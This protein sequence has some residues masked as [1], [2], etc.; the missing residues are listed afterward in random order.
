MSVHSL[1]RSTRS[2]PALA[3]VA[4]LLAGALFLATA[5][6][7]AA[8]DRSAPLRSVQTAD[9]ELAAINDMMPGFGGMFLDEAGT[10]T[11]YVTADRAG[12]YRKAFGGTVR[13]I[14][15]QWEF[16]Q[17]LR[18]RSDLRALLHAPGVVLLDADE[19]KNRVRVGVAP[20][21]SH[22]ARRMIEARLRGLGVPDGAVVFDETEPIHPL[23]TL[24]DAFSP[25]PGGVE[26]HWSNFLCT[27]GFNIRRGDATDACYF[28]TND[29]CTD[30]QGTVTGTIYRQ[31]VFGVQ[32][33]EEV[34][35]PPFFTGAPCPAGRICRYSDAA[36]ARYFDPNNCEF[37][38]IA[39]TTGIGSVT[40]DPVNPRWMIVAKILSPPVGRIVA[41]TGRT[42]G[43]TENVVAATCADVNVFG[44]NITRLCQSIVNAGVGGGDSGSPVFLRRIPTSQAALGGI[45]WGGN[46][47]GTQFVF[48]PIENIEIDFGFPL[49]VH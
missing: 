18:W 47:P 13:V 34:Y 22:A 3:A 11:V 8:G 46:G 39:R 25:V 43:W 44:S 49:T 14:D 38:K 6:P 15:G 29:H 41:K 19:T 28:V 31:P 5:T 32:I 45:L 35:D 4:L 23:V 20:G 2:V 40:A 37:G 36:V 1:F 48:S 27:L 33:A 24:S 30:V 16:R 17:L 7:A 9:D 26:I 12:L 10:P 42:T 21:T